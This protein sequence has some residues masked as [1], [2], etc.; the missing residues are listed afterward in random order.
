MST[1][2]DEASSIPC[3]GTALLI[4]EW[5]AQEACGVCEGTD[6]KLYF[7]WHM[8][9]DPEVAKSCMEKGQEF[10]CES[11]RVVDTIGMRFNTQSTDMLSD[12]KHA[13]FLNDWRDKVENPEVAD[14]FFNTPWRKCKG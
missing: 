9:S 8:V 7:F 13:Q 6:G 3:T 4:R 2:P 10:V 1:L 5:A 12:E 14:L 11:V